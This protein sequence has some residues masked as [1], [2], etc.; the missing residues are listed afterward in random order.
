[1][2][3]RPA[4]VFC[5]FRKSLKNLLVSLCKHIHIVL[6]LGVPPLIICAS[7]AAYLSRLIAITSKEVSH[8]YTTPSEIKDWMIE[9][10][11]YNKFNRLKK[12][13]RKH[14]SIGIKQMLYIALLTQNFWKKKVGIPD[15]NI[16]Y[17][18]LVPGTGIEPVQP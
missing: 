7:K 16:S 17:S 1:M 3:C 13:C 14:F 6:I 10:M 2:F 15:L 5:T 4:P 12:I 8:K 9:N 11:K 18:D